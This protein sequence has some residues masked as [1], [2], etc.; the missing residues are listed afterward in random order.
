LEIIKESDFRKLA[1]S[2][3]SG[4]YL[5]F[6]DEDYLKAHA[7]KA[8]EAAVCSDPS[9]AVFNYMKIDATAYSISS[10][11]DALTPLPM[12]S[13]KKLVT[14]DGINFSALKPKEVDELVELLENFGEYDYNVLIISVPAELIEEGN[15]PKY[16]SKILKR[17][18]AVITPVYFEKISGEKLCAWVEKHFSHNGVKASRDVCR[19]L[20]DYSGKSMFT[21]SQETEKISFYALSHG[22]TEITRDDVYEIANPEI[23][24]EAFGLANALSDGRYADALKALSVEKFRR[25][26]P[27]ILMS[28]VSRVLCE[29][30]TVKA[31]LDSGYSAKEISS[32]LKMNEYKAR[33]YCT[34]AASKSKQRIEKGIVLCSEAD[35]ALKT[36]KQSYKDYQI[37]EKLICSL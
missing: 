35:R 1:K 27:V 6:G 24:A 5:F 36:Q 31:L 14:I 25:V 21:L 12:M 30:M 9:F 4:A 2:G 11:V 19:A 18:Q 32:T 23:S 15:L 20:I 7:I 16:P 10:L 8:A 29:L 3:L 33:L 17:L 13:D 37:I 22:R 26:E 28:E 34:S